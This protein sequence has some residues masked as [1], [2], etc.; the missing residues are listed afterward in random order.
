MA[1]LVEPIFIL[2]NATKDSLIVT[3]QDKSDKASNS[4]AKADAFAAAEPGFHGD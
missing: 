4:Y 2:E 3:E 1:E